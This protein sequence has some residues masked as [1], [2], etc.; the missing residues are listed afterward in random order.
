MP[1]S[2]VGTS[3]YENLNKPRYLKRTVFLEHRSSQNSIS[4]IELFALLRWFLSSKSH[5]S[6]ES[7][8]NLIPIRINLPNRNRPSPTQSQDADTP[9]S[10]QVIRETA[11]LKHLTELKVGHWS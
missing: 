10:Y 4:H 6:G 3:V 2:A 8:A 1:C 7:L 5:R 11:S 9:A